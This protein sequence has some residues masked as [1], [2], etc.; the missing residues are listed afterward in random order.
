MLSISKIKN[1]ADFLHFF[2]PRSDVQ[3][4]RPISSEGFYLLARQLFG[5]NPLGFHLIAW[6]FFVLNIILVWKLARQFLMNKQNASVLAFLYATSAIHYN[7]LY[8]IVNFSYI[9]AGFWYFFRFFTFSKG[10]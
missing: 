9:L 2:I 5:L 6:L 4:Y 1:I 7:S 3:F 8:W 10:R